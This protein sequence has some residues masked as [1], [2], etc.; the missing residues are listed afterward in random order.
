MLI[1][2]LKY[3]ISYIPPLKNKYPK[4]TYTVLTLL[5]LELDSKKF[6]CAKYEPWSLQYRPMLPS[7]KIKI[8]R[9]CVF[10]D[11]T[12]SAQLRSGNSFAVFCFIYGARPPVSVCVCA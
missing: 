9:A 12:L 10:K 7:V 3:G 11:G 4:A 8:M 6:I 2:Q 5:N 1:E